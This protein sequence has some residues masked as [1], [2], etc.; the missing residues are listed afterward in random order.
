MSFASGC[1]SDDHIDKGKFTELNRTTQDLKSVITSIKPCDVP[2]E[3]LQRLASGIT[4]AKGKAASKAERDLITA[5]SSLLTTY[6]DGLLLCR[7]R[8]HLSK[9]EFVPKGRIYVTQELDPLVEKYSLSTERHLY[10]PTGQLW[11]SIDGDSIK[12]IWENA[13]AQSKNIEN[14]VNYN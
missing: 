4:A 2:D 8:T 11:K 9:F 6:K 12:V 3:L 13:D 7:S 10:E 5:Y 1:G 14:M